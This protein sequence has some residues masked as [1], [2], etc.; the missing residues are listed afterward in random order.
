MGD[1]LATLIR[2]PQRY[3]DTDSAASIDDSR[4]RRDVSGHAGTP[5][6]AASAI[7]A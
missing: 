7:H 1:D 2:H 5:G 4:Q 6:S 3:G